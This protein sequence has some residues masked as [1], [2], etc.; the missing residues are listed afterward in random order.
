MLRLRARVSNKKNAQATINS[1]TIE[2][3][4]KGEIL[5]GLLGW[6]PNDYCIKKK[7]GDYSDDRAG[8]LLR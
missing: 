5:E 4:E 8:V 3:R 2:R 1:I 6:C 7:E